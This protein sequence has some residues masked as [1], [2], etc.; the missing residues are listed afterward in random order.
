M[1]EVA[2][3]GVDDNWLAWW[4]SGA[5]S[6]V[7]GEAG[8]EQTAVVGTTDHGQRIHAFYAREQ[9]AYKGCSFKDANGFCNYAHRDK[10][11]RVDQERTKKKEQRCKSLRSGREEEAARARETTEWVRVRAPPAVGTK[12]GGL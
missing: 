11:G 3:I 12:E 9:R 4:L 7:G 6:L 2:L 8:K 5:M 1:D 10:F